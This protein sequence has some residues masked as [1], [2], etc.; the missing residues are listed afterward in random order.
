LIYREGNHRVVQKKN[1]SALGRSNGLSPSKHSETQPFKHARLLLKACPQA[2]LPAREIK[3]IEREKFAATGVDCVYVDI[4]HIDE[5]HLAQ[6]KP[7]MFSATNQ[8]SKL[9]H[10]EFRHDIGKMNGADLFSAAWS[11]LLLTKFTSSLAITERPLA[12]LPKT[13]D[14][15]F[16]FF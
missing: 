8:G 7:Q 11:T 10:A 4:L 16:T 12:N 6:G 14:K 13:G 5:M 3:T 9:S 15:P 1:T 2:H